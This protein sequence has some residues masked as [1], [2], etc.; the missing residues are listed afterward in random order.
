[1]QVLPYAARRS[2]MVSPVEAVMVRKRFNPLIQFILF[3]HAQFQRFVL[4]KDLETSIQM[5]L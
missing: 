4:C 3:P 2:V 1:M 5:C